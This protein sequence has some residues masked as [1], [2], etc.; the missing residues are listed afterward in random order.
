VLTAYCVSQRRDDR[1][2]P[3]LA[4]TAVSNIDH[5]VRDTFHRRRHQQQSSRP[6]SAVSNDGALI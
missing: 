4:R 2:P 5:D 6:G 3:A 1:L